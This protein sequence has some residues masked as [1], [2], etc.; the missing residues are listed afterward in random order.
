MRHTSAS[1]LPTHMKYGMAS[2]VPIADCDRAI[3]RKVNLQSKYNF[4]RIDTCHL[5]LRLRY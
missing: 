5:F 2:G 3:A 4:E 1:G